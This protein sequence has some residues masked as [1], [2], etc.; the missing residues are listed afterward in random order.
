MLYRDF[1]DISFHRFV[2]FIYGCLA[3]FL[4]VYLLTQSSPLPSDTEREAEAGDNS[5]RPGTPVQQQQHVRYNFATTFTPLLTPRT[6]RIPDTGTPTLRSR[7]SRASLAGISPGFLLLATT[8]GSP[9]L[10]GIT[11]P[12]FGTVVPV[13]AESGSRR[14]TRSESRT[15]LVSGSLEEQHLDGEMADRS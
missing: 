9:D 3:T 5:P 15:P 6:I 2:V 14:R 11:Q 7:G 4:G 12:L 8:A 1:E 10:G 13:P